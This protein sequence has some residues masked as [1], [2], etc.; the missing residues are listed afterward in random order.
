MALYPFC[1][2]ARGPHERPLLVLSAGRDDWVDPNVCAR[3][4]RLTGDD[5]LPV[6]F[7]L[8]PPAHHGFDI[9]GFGAPRY[10]GEA[11]NPDGF[12]AGGGT[13]GYHPPSHAEAVETVRKFLA[14]HLGIAPPS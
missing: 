2:F 7:K 9:E 13:L 14:K 5:P 4:A 1:S 3:M 12:A 8:L 11:I 6:R 10:V